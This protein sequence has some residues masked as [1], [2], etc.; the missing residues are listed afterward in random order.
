MNKDSLDRIVVE[1]NAKMERVI[2]WYQENKKWLD[3]E[4]FHAPMESGCVVLQ[5]EQIE[6]TFESK[7]DT[8]VE[9]MVYANG[10]DTPAF[11]FDYNPFT[12]AYGNHRF[13]GHLSSERKKWMEQL[14]NFDRMDY[15]ESLKYHALMQFAAHY[16]E[17]VVVKDLRRTSQ[18]KKASKRLGKSARRPKPLVRKTYVVMDFED[19]QLGKRH[20]TKPVHEVSVKGFYRTTK[21]G[22]RVWV[23]PFTKYKDKGDRQVKE[24]TV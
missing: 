24:Y 20:Y 17:I 4:E 15:K 14:I 18:T 7:S 16:E 19:S 8:V 22:K 3:Q 21:S 11:T 9:I 12:H 1:T 23:R 6:F 10:Y 13:P 2:L 5:E